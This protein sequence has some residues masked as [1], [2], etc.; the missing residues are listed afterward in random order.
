MIRNLDVIW[1][2][3][4]SRRS[5]LP[6]GVTCSEVHFT[7]IGLAACGGMELRREKL[8]ARISPE[9]THYFKW[10]AT[11]CRDWAVETVVPMRKAAAE[12]EN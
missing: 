3:M 8:E 4:G 1:Q 11:E 7:E 10:E 5:L 6:R 9:S 12:V 2:T